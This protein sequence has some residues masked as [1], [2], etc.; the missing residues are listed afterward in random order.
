MKLF[1]INFDPQK[2]NQLI[3]EGYGRTYDFDYHGDQVTDPRPKALTLGK[4]K[5]SKGNDLMAGI[6]LNY[7]SD[8]QV[9]RLQ[10]NLQTVLRS[11]NL[12][13]RA[14]V[15]RHLMPDIFNSAYRTY[16]KDAVNNVDA[17][18][19]KFLSVQKD[20]DPS[21]PINKLSVPKP[22]ED[23]NV[24]TEPDDVTSPKLQSEPVRD[25]DPKAEP[26]K[27]ESEAEP[28]PIEP[29]NIGTDDT[30]PEDL[31]PEEEPEDEEI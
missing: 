26:E 2:H 29:Q 19:L 18:T 4:W 6:N 24:S 10:G 9:E 30:E 13:T 5:S 11:R 15:L 14:R 20:V 28:E 7:L 3:T 22:E 25:V 12:K 1:E 27:P 31:E 21:E 8:E 23:P 17:N 16:N